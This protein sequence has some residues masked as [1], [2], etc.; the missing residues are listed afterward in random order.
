M[1]KK[2]LNKYKML[3]GQMYSI[4]KLQNP[5]LKIFDYGL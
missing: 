3:Q 4:I 1:K 5:K 2:S